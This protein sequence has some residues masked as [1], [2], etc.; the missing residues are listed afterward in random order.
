MAT[1]YNPSVPTSA[2]VAITAGDHP[3]SLSPINDQVMGGAVWD[4]WTTGNSG[5][6]FNPATQ[7]VNTTQIDGQTGFFE[8]LTGFGQALLSGIGVQPEPQ[9]ARRAQTQRA[10]WG[11]GQQQR[12]GLEIEQI[13]IFGLIG[14]G[15]YFA[16]K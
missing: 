13:A 9:A 7:G 14:V 10:F 16:F 15:L 6:I 4:A 1:T 12:A 8:R 2:G 5:T 3:S 11:G